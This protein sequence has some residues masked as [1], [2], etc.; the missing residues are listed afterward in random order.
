MFTSP[1]D[2]SRVQDLHSVSQNG[3]T[4]GFTPARRPRFESRDYFP[5]SGYQTVGQSN[6]IRI[7]RNTSDFWPYLSTLPSLPHVHLLLAVR[8]LTLQDAHF[9]FAVRTLV[10]LC[11][12]FSVA[13]R[14]L[15]LLCV[16]F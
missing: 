5:V 3:S 2:R 16:H 14:A 1:Y 12:H 8:T 9:L 7:I 10:L 15:V 11:A 4:T 6:I 13:V